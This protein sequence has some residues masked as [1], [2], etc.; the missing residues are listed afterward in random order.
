[1]E[2]SHTGLLKQ[3]KYVVCKIFVQNMSLIDN[4]R[5]HEHTKMKLRLD[6]QQDAE[7][8]R[9]LYDEHIRQVCWRHFEFQSTFINNAKLKLPKNIQ[10]L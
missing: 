6:L 4:R 1:M 5:E 10:S 2:D 8:L 9:K 7:N 3:L